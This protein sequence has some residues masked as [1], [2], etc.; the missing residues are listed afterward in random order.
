MKKL[1]NQELIFN[2]NNNNITSNCN[3]SSNNHNKIYNKSLEGKIILKKTNSKMH[4]LHKNKKFKRFG[5]R[6]VVRRV[7]KK[8]LL[9]IRDKTNKMNCSKKNYFNKHSNNYNNKGIFKKI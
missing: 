7:S 4:C 9:L 6:V 5:Q 2:H 3:S 1:I 8:V